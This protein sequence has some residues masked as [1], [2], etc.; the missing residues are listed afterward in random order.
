MGI[1]VEGGGDDVYEAGAPL[2]HLLGTTEPLRRT[3]SLGFGDFQGFGL[4]LEEAGRDRYFHMPGR[5][6][7]TT[8]APA[9][10]STGLFIDR[11]EGGSPTA[12]PASGAEG[13]T[14]GEILTAYAGHYLPAT[15]TAPRGGA[16]QFANPDWVSALES[17]GHTV[18]EL[19]PDGGP[20]RF[21]SGLVQ[22]GQVAPVQGVESLPVGRY[23]FF[24]EV[25]PFMKGTI[26]V[27]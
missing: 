4:M 8:V 11:S 12:R 24:C 23:A 13:P 16:V 26:V 10:D 22:V 20:P 6:D 9:A 25:H 2:D 19:R 18:T 3:G 15:V 21:A 27:R 17:L 1:L 5:A 14:A 7:D